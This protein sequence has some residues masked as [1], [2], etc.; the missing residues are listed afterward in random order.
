MG[1]ANLRDLRSRKLFSVF[2]WAVLAYNLPVILWGA[3]VRASFSGDGCGAN[4]PTCNGQFVL[5]KMTVP[6]AIEY[7][8]RLMTSVDVFAVLAMLVWAWLAFGK[9]AP[10]RRYAAWS[11]VFL[12]I[13]ALL[14][15]GLVLFRYVAK[16]QS[17]GR[18]WYLSAHLVNT[19]LLLGTLAATAWLAQSST[20]E[21][22]L[23]RAKRLNLGG[24]AVVIFVSVTGT[25]AA[26]GDTL[27]PA[28]S[29]SGGIAQDL[30]S[31]TSLLLRLRVLHPAIAIAG[32]LYLLWMSASV[33]RNA[34]RDDRARPR[35][36]RAAGGLIAITVMQAGAGML[37]LLL[38]APLPMQLI[39]LLMADLVW[40]A[41][42]VLVLETASAGTVSTWSASTKA[43][44]VHA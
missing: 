28:S 25:V 9:G 39:H 1:S 19:L 14:G 2:A 36:V 24:L 4:W 32:A 15:A 41:V 23:L 40:I 37:N 43:A 33:I 3:Y 30:S 11:F 29:L 13:E 38:L 27:Y 12:T 31:S 44:S 7:T 26:L 20:E 21:F 35:S 5:H 8:H 18:V 22:R 10:V 42:V 6:M 17:A 16:D 34:Q